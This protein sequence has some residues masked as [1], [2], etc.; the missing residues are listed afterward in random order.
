MPRQ[1]PIQLCLSIEVSNTITN[2]IAI[3][4]ASEIVIAIPLVLIGISL[5]QYCL[6]IAIAIA[7][8]I[9]SENGIDFIHVFPKISVQERALSTTGASH[10][11]S[12]TGR[13]LTVF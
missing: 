3:K 9:E 13:I 10:S 4:F 12:S 6:A 5:H 11:K 8:K 1:T 7:I 2:T